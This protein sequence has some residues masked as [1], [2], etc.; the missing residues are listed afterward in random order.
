MKGYTRWL[1]A[2]IIAIAAF[3]GVAANAA[4][5]QAAPLGTTPITANMASCHQSDFVSRIEC[6]TVFV[7]KWLEYTGNSQVLQQTVLVPNW[8]VEVHRSATTGF[9]CGAAELEFFS[10][11]MHH[12][13]QTTYVSLRHDP[14]LFTTTNQVIAALVHET[15]HGMQEQAG[16]DP[17]ATTLS[18][19]T[20]PRLFPFEQSSDCWSGAAFKWFV[21]QG[22]RTSAQAEDAAT[23]MASIGNEGDHGHGNPRQREAAFR[24]GLTGGKDECNAYWSRKVF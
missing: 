4:S 18:G 6:G 21:S 23:F 8:T 1:A 10:F 17:V 9:I 13:D 15:G 7:E 16:K 5:A 22:L 14:Q 20:S 3:T 24:L 2:S 19:I 12:C 11:G